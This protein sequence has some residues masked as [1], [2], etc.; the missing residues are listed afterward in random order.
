MKPSGSAA[1]PERQASDVS[2]LR[3]LPEPV[4]RALE[5][6]GAMLHE[7]AAEAATSRPRVELPRRSGGVVGSLRRHDIYDHVD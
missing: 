4:A 7:H 3:G 2:S 1:E 6:M 5:V